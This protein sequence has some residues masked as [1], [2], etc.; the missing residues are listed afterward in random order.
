MPTQRPFFANFFS[1]FRARSSPVFQA[2]SSPTGAI[3]PSTL[4]ATAHVATTTTTVTST[5]AARSIST[6]AVQDASTQSTNSVSPQTVKTS[7]T[8]PFTTTMASGSPGTTFYSIPKSA[9][10]P[11]PAPHNH[12]LALSPPGHATPV[13]RGRQRR[14]SGSSN[15]SGGFMDA[16]GSEKWYIGGRT[17]TGEERFYQLGLATTSAGKR[18][19]SLDR[20]SL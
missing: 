4:A 18:V 13:P 17:A 20:L 14:D 16:M 12:S 5:N 10:P 8:S 6:K 15:S 1:A 11:S 7:N 3:S 9:R 19:R 2:K